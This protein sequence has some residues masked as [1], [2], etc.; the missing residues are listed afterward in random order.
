M[1]KTTFALTLVLGTGLAL[2]PAAPRT[3]AAAVTAGPVQAMTTADLSASQ[4]NSLFTPVASDPVMTQNFQFAGSPASG[5]IQSEV[6][7]GNANTAAA[8]L[9]AYAYQVTVNNVNDA[10]GTPIHVDSASFKFNATPV[11]SDFTSTGK[12][13]FGYVVNDGAIGGLTQQT[14]GQAPAGLSWQANNQ[15]GTIRASFLDPTSGASSLNGGTNSAAFVLLSTQAPIADTT[16]LPTINI[17]GPAA[18]T[19]TPTV[20]SASP[21]EVSPIPV[22]EPSALLAWSGMAAAVALVRRVRKSRPAA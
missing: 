5:T 20:Y 7:Q 10:D 16:K 22:P 1:N 3:H 6:F 2:G 8:G 15:T 17:G 19:T 13:V 21:G 9:F 4:F 12:S 18:T 11:A 14:G